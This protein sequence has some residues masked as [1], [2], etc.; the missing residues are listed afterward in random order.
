[1]MLSV[2]MCNNFA[3][4]VLQSAMKSK[5]QHSSMVLTMATIASLFQLPNP[6]ARQPMTKS[7]W[8][9]WLV[10]SVTRTADEP[11]VK[12]LLRL[13]IPILDQPSMHMGRGDI[14]VSLIDLTRPA[15]TVIEMAIGKIIAGNYIQRRSQTGAP[16]T[17]NTVILCLP[18]V[19][20]NMNATISKACLHCVAGLPFPCSTALCCRAIHS[21]CHLSCLT[22]LC[23]GAIL[24]LLVCTVMRSHSVFARLHCDAGYIKFHCLWSS[25][26]ERQSYLC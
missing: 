17:R 3:A 6:S 18:M 12:P 2:H 7:M 13:V 24:S 20:L 16:S 8:S 25:R 11:L 19:S 14:R 4:L 23:C 9:N 5:H 26:H 15:T 10:N 21:I 22:V 1:M